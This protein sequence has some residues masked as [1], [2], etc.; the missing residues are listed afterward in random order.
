MLQGSRRGELRIH[1]EGHE[2]TQ[3]FSITR[4]NRRE[5]TLLCRVTAAQ[6]VTAACRGDKQ[7]VTFLIAKTLFYGT[8]NR[9]CVSRSTLLYQ[10]SQ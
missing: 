10:G 3:G 2:G 9:N 1:R 6:T 4:N 5:V 7:A 8:P